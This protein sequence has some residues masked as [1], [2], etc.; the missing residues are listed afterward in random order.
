MSEGLKGVSEKVGE[1]GQDTVE[2]QTHRLESELTDVVRKIRE[3]TPE[4]IKNKEY[5]E[6]LKKV[7][8]SV[9]AVAY[10]RASVHQI[11]KGA[12]TPLH[13]LATQ[14]TPVTR[15]ARASFVSGGFLA[16]LP[17]VV[18]V[19]QLVFQYLPK[20]LGLPVAESPAE[21]V[22]TISILGAA[23]ATLMWET[24]SPGRRRAEERK[25][26]AQLLK[27][28]LDNEEKM[29]R[30]RDVAVQ[31]DTDM[32]FETCGEVVAEQVPMPTARNASVLGVKRSGTLAALVAAAIGSGVLTHAT[33][34]ATTGA[35]ADQA[36]RRVI[37]PG[38]LKGRDPVEMFVEG[39]WKRFAP[40]VS[41]QEILGATRK[42][43]GM[44]TDPKKK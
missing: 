14:V 41:A 18:P 5:D 12:T 15:G 1:E 28:I 6:D 38:L 24:V 29:S 16:S 3:A 9:L 39:A 22:A 27:Q 36:V 25:E 33:V 7:L 10:T 37:S 21:F 42:G 32:L 8:L 26:A 30:I 13:R 19:V 20:K 34:K 4:R 2:S 31:G 44:T 43:L 11:D 40:R 35:A 23:A 17:A